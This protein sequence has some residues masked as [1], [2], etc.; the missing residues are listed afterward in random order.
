V[1]KEFFEDGQQTV[2]GETT[3]YFQAPSEDE[4]FNFIRHGRA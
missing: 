4:G 3:K 2:G 1:L